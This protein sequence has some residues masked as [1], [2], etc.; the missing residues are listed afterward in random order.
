VPQ[1]AAAAASAECLYTGV[2][3]QLPTAIVVVSATYAADLLAAEACQGVPQLLG[4]HHWGVDYGWACHKRLIVVGP[5]ER[6]GAAQV[7][8]AAGGNVVVASGLMEAHT[9]AVLRRE[10]EG[11]AVADA[12]EERLVVVGRIGRLAEARSTA[13]DPVVVGLPRVRLGLKVG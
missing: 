13:V 11:N 6:V 10:E 8:Y 1:L 3:H 5:E 9:G 12:R 2:A 7:W 4:L